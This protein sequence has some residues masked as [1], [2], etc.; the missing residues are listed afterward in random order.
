MHIC[1]FMLRCSLSLGFTW[2]GLES[3]VSTLRFASKAARQYGRNR[4]DGGKQKLTHTHI[5]ACYAW[6][7]LGSDSNLLLV[8]C[9][10]RLKLPVNMAVTVL[11]EVTQKHTHSH[12]YAL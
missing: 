2:F 1:I 8:R 4:V 5:Y 7:L 3:P 12:I 10:S 11:M 6:G 9:V